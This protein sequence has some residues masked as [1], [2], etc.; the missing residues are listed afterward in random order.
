MTFFI[1]YA[2]TYYDEMN[3][4]IFEYYGQNSQAAVIKVHTDQGDY[5][6]GIRF[7][8][9][10]NGVI[11]PFIIVTAILIIFNLIFVFILE[12]IIKWY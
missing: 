7:F 9:F 10:A 8:V 3:G 11:T 6:A 2:L 1:K 5:F 12:R 4:H